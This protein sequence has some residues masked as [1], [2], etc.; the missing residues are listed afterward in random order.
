MDAAEIVNVNPMP[1]P[2]IMVIGM[3]AICPSNDPA[4]EMACRISIDPI[5]PDQVTVV[6][7]PRPD[8]RLVEAG[9]QK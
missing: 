7:T 2:S 9:E 5:L 4:I 8:N 1:A 3:P 6:P